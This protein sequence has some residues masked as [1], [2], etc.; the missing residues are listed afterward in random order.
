MTAIL[1]R[2][3][4][5]EV[6]YFQQVPDGLQVAIQ[7]VSEWRYRELYEENPTPGLSLKEALRTVLEKLNQFSQNSRFSYFCLAMI[8]GLTV[9]PT[10]RC[11]LPNESFTRLFFQELFHSFFEQKK[12]EDFKGYY[13]PFLGKYQAL[14]EAILV[15]EKMLQVSDPLQAGSKLLDISEICLEGYAIFPG[16]AE[17]RKLFDWWL[18]EAIPAACLQIF[19]SH[20]YTIKGLGQRQESL[21]RLRSYFWAVVRQEREKKLNDSGSLENLLA[22]MAG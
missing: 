10:V 7:Q 9:R 16:S 11:Y 17:R 1:V 19:P 20:I 2:S 14:D 13:E 3:H 6:K 18:L 12:V 4:Q 15:L 22:F 21:K 8:L 5:S